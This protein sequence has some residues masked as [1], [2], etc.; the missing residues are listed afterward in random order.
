M[1]PPRWNE[2]CLTAN[3][4][5]EYPIIQGPLLRTEWGRQNTGRLSRSISLSTS[6]P[7]LEPTGG[8]SACDV[9]AGWSII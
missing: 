5:I 9:A 7:K 1:M 4:G 6:C 2:N 8:I 3:L